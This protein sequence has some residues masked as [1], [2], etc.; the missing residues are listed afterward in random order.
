MIRS[1]VEI[2]SFSKLS[3]YT[4]RFY[5]F[6]IFD[7]NQSGGEEYRENMKSVRGGWLQKIDDKFVLFPCIK[8]IISVKINKVKEQFPQYTRGASSWNN[9]KAVGMYPKVPNGDDTWRLVCSGGMFSKKHEYLFDDDTDD[10]LELSEKE[11]KIFLT[12]NEPNPDFEKYLNHIKNGHKIAVFYLMNNSE[13]IIAIGLSKMIR[14]PYKKNVKSIIDKQQSKESKRDLCEMIFG[15]AE[16]NDA[17]KGRIQFTHAFIK[18]IVKD[19]NLNRKSGVLGSPKAS[20]FPLY[21]KQEGNRYHSYDNP[22]GI[23][24]RKKYRIHGNNSNV[25]LP[26]GNG[27]KKT[28]TTLLAIPTGHKFKFRINLHNMRKV[29]IGAILSALTFHM[30]SDAYHNVGQAKGCG[31]GKLSNMHIILNNLKYDIADYIKFFEIEMNNWCSKNGL[32][33]WAQTEQVNN[34]VAIAREHHNQD[35]SYMDL[36]EFAFY[37]RNKNFSKLSE[38]IKPIKSLIK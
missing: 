2:L 37:K 6:R 17:I 35:L 20:Y 10:G 19:E 8:D 13:E 12:V 11:L 21:L 38:T 31:F 30:N 26:Q 28:M 22:L 3:Q 24:G 32:K 18:D 15:N 25:N 29:E 9:N 34:L 5:G 1:N 4:D 33:N 16:E 23:S 27:N 7:S 36:K 14:Y